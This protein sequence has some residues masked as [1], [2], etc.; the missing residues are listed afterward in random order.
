ML[1]S[2][3]CGVSVGLFYSELL[4]LS[5]TYAITL[6]P[7]SHSLPG[8]FIIMTTYISLAYPQWHPSLFLCTPWSPVHKVIYRAIMPDLLIIFA[9]ITVI[10]VSQ[11]HL[12]R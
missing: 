1:V 9:A 4:I 2:D 3:E 10:L 7:I 6:T 8:P 11:G 5:L 12:L